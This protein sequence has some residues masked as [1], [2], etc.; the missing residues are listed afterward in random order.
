[1]TL[2]Y[3]LLLMADLLVVRIC[4]GLANSLADLQPY[5]DQPH[6]DRGVKAAEQV[7]SHLFYVAFVSLFTKWKRQHRRHMCFLLLFYCR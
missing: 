1:M 4:H 7:R 2:I 3:S 6:Q 5:N